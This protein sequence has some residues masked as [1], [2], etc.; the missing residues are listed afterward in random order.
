MRRKSR[1]EARNSQMPVI[2][3]YGEWVKLFGE[4]RLPIAGILRLPFAHHVDHLNGTVK[5][6]YDELESRD[7]HTWNTLARSALHPEVVERECLLQAS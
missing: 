7:D 5:L 3:S 2:R 1:A 6:T 4:G